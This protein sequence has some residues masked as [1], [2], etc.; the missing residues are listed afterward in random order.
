MFEVWHMESGSVKRG[1]KEGSRQ[2]D[3]RGGKAGKKRGK[4][5]HAHAHTHTHF[6]FRKGQAL[7]T[8]QHASSNG[9]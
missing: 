5:L 7:N 9:G 8:L 1:R 6:Q 4:T 2:E 3:G